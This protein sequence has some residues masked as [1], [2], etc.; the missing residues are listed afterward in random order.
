MNIKKIEQHFTISDQITLDDIKVLAELGVKKL[1]CNR[2]DAEQKGQLSS[3][4]TIQEA[5]KYNIEF[6][7]ISSPGREIPQDSINQFIE[8]SKNNTEKTHA[9]CR[10]GTRTSFFWA[11]FKATTMT[12]KKVIEL[13]KSLDLNFEGISEQLIQ[14]HK[15][16]LH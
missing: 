14:V 8:F 9:Y 11:L 13:G 16:H 4:E 15:K 1:I 7:H 12:P 10:T 6:I 2:P 5:K 3:A